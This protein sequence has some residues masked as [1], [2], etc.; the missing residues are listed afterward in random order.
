MPSV[1]CV[2]TL[3]TVRSELPE[4]AVVSRRRRVCEGRA[5]VVVMLLEDLFISSAVA[6]VLRPRSVE[7][8]LSRAGSRQS[9]AGWDYESPTNM[10]VAAPVR[11]TTGTADRATSARRAVPSRFVA[12]LHAMVL[13][14]ACGGASA[15]DPVTPAPVAPMRETE[16]APSTGHDAELREAD[17]TWRR[18]IAAM[19]S[20]EAGAAETAAD[21][22]TASTIEHYE[23]ARVAALQASR[24]E[25]ESMSDL[26]RFTVLSLRTVFQDETLAAADGRALFVAVAER[27]DHAD[28]ILEA[29]F[30]RYEDDAAVARVTVHG[31]EDTVYEVPLVRRDDGAF[32][33]DMKAFMRGLLEANL[34]RGDESTLE[35]FEG[36]RDD[37]EGQ[38]AWEP[39]HGDDQSAPTGA[40]GDRAVHVR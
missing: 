40:E 36:R 31:V 16:A 38:G 10:N 5:G 7:T 22:V 25:V 18:F 27:T 29:A 15:P 30:L 2:E 8:C 1:R 4:R 33:V 12:W 11:I 23:R 19:A 6:S 9:G 20:D 3:P 14:A 26:D 17:A 21:L 32:R 37:I 13:L 34:A 28:T 35:I 39:L 24:E